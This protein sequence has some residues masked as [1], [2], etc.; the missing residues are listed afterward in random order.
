MNKYQ[1]IIQFIPD[2]TEEAIDKYIAKAQRIT[3]LSR[4]DKW[5]TQKAC[6]SC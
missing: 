4:I 3:E 1:M 2:I 6:L 5:R